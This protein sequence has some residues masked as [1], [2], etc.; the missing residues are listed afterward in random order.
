[1]NREIVADLETQRIPVSRGGLIS[2]TQSRGPDALP[3][4]ATMLTD[5]FAAAHL[6]TIHEKVKWTF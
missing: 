1:M 3:G 6:N 2:F 4:R 5:Q